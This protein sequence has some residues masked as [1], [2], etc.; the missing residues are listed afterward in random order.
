MKKDQFRGLSTPFILSKSHVNGEVNIN[1]TTLLL[2][3]ESD[4]AD[5]NIVEKAQVL[6]ISAP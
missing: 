2:I 5:S 6:E 3:D 4:S 1:E